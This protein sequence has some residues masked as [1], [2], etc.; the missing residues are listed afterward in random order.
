MRANPLRRRKPPRASRSGPS[1]GVS[2][3]GICEVWTLRVSTLSPFAGP[4]DLTKFQSEA[5]AD[6]ARQGIKIIDG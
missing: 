1:A 2:A 4:Q 6:L 3:C 5:E